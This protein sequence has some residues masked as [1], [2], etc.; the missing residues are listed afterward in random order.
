[1]QEPFFFSQLRTRDLCKS[2]IVH[3]ENHSGSPACGE[4]TDQV[5]A[6][7]RWIGVSPCAQI[8]KRKEYIRDRLCP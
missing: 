6:A 1:M 8:D 7:G 5:A 3:N 2:F 4:R